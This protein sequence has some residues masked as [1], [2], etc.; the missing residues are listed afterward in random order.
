[1]IKSSLMS[2]VDDNIEQE[3]L[4]KI[5]KIIEDM[6]KKSYTLSAIIL[7]AITISACGGGNGGNNDNN[8]SSSQRSSQPEIADCTLI[9]NSITVQNGSSCELT[10]GDAALY[11]ITAGELSCSNNILTFNNSQYSAGNGGVG[12]NGLTI[13]CTN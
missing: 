5:W 3:S 9:M 10:S 1:M 12:M 6:M 2:D 13:I 4:I 7:T 8:S 11:G